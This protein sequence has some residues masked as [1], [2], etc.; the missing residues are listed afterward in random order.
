[1]TSSE[2]LKHTKGEFPVVVAKTPYL[3]A[4]GY[5]KNQLSLLGNV[6][7]QIPIVFKRTAQ[8]GLMRAI[9]RSAKDKSYGENLKKA[10]RNMKEIATSVDKKDVKTSYLKIDPK[11]QKVLWDF[12]CS[13]GLYRKEQ[14]KFIRNMG[15]VYLIAE[16]ESFLQ[17][18]L[19]T[20]FLKKPEILASSQ[21]TITFEELVKFK[22]IAYARQHIIEKETSY[23][24]S[25]DIEE[26]GK[27]IE[28][29]FGMKIFHFDEWTEFKERFYRRNTLIHNSGMIDRHYRLKTGYH[30][31]CRQM[32]VSKQYLN[33]SIDLFGKVAIVI[34]AMFDEKFQETSTSKVT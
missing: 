24:L 6:N 31:K 27:Y 15:L 8:Q 29:K 5:L 7:S 26:M 34:F 20:T 32:I 10:Y 23:I 4:Y 12:L 11:T 25:L 28:Q 22:D 14:V 9:L 30:G 16:F 17:K 13:S 18:V 19:E 1:M 21:K 33:K 2:D 3:L